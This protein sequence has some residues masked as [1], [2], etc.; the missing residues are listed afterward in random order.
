MEHIDNAKIEQLRRN[1][2]SEPLDIT[3]VFED[4][5]RQFNAWFSEAMS[6]EVYEPNAMTLATVDEHNAPQARIVLLKGI[7]ENGFVF[8]TN[9]A[10]AKGEEM[11]LNDKVNL[12]FFWPELHRQVRIDGIVYKIPE[13]QSLEY[14]QSRPKGSQ[15]GAWVSQQSKVVENRAVLEHKY[16]ELETQYTGVDV[17]PKPA[18]W[19]GYTVKPYKM[20]FWQGRMN[21][22]HDR[23]RY[24]LEELTPKKWKID[25]L[26][27]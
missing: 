26:A 9:Y 25:R 13:K 10:S 21:R 16:A 24:T 7:E 14:F 22:L 17:L 20:E 5:F 15:L 1:Y 8:Y 3:D 11:A 27:P 4:P 23:L 2:L 12:M 19:G 6:A 18:H